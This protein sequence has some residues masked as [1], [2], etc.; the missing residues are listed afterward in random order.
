MARGTYPPARARA[1][2][3]IPYPL[4]IVRAILRWGLEIGRTLSCTVLRVS[5]CTCGEWVVGREGDDGDA[6]G[7]VGCE[8]L[9][10]RDRR[11][12]YLTARQGEGDREVRRYE[13]RT[14]TG[15]KEFRSVRWGNN[16]RSEKPARGTVSCHH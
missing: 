7:D 1:G 2:L 8:M 9:L 3:S 10:A 4:L 11:W 12:W 16:G 13:D 6:R 14:K 5:V 15:G